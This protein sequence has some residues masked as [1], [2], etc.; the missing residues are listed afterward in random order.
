M[1]LE[2]Y[3]IPATENRVSAE[4][5]ARASGL[6]T[7]KVNKPVK[8]AIHFSRGGGCSCSL[9]SEDA[10]WDKPVWALEN[11]VLE[12]LAAA[13]ELLGKEAGGFTLRAIWIGDEVETEGRLSLS[14]MLDE[15]RGNRVRNRHTYKVKA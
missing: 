9:L 2:F 8:G 12:G 4:R 11:G 6:W 10:D 5:L 13:L 3:V 7:K 15:V 14:Q 1:C